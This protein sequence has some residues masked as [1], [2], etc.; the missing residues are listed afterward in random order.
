MKIELKFIWG[1]ML[2]ASVVYAALGYALVHGFIPFEFP[3]FEDAAIFSMV[4]GVVSTTCLALAYALPPRLT[5]VPPIQAA[6]VRFA[7]IEAVGVLGLVYVFQTGDF[8]R[9]AFF[10]A[11]SFLGLLV[12]FPK[13]EE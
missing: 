10:F 5:K 12:A 11:A 6:L 7:L 2:F 13:E 4:L 8:N 9:G 1:M 3:D